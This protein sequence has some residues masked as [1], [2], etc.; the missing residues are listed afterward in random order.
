METEIEI[1]TDGSTGMFSKKKIREKTV[2]LTSDIMRD[3]VGTGYE[4]ILRRASAQDT[5]V[6]Q[7]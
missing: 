1:D 4:M 7:S 3:Y 6:R 2:A 5:P